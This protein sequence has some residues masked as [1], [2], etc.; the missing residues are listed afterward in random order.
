MS[1]I[2]RTAYPKYSKR[3]RI[4]QKDLDE[5]YTLT[6]T[7]V[8]LMNKYARKPQPKLNFAIQLKTFQK[9]SYFVPIN[10]VP[11]LI[12]FH[13]K[14]SLR[15]HHRT[16]IGYDDLSP[17][18]L[19]T[20]RSVIRT[21]L[22]ITKWEYQEIDA[23]RVHVARKS[24]IKFA[25]NISHSMNNI[26]DIVHAVVQHFIESG[27]ELPSFHTLDQLVRHTRHMVNNKIFS[28][29]SQKVLSSGTD[30]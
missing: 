9:L 6:S 7:E 16:R 8:D 10:E 14:K 30:E 23:K 22:K 17:T 12:I 27:Y 26:A 5:F 13:L 25:Y 4:R 19:Y 1:T 28:A 20:H 21:Y 29:V 24:A 11:E 15:F 3:R 18:T 2:E